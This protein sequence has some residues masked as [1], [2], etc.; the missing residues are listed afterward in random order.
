MNMYEE[1]QQTN[2]D[3]NNE[4]EH[5]LTIPPDPFPEPNKY[6]KVL[7]PAVI[8]GLISLC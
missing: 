7:I 4:D 6:P 3:E 2:D 8:G 1:E 5:Q